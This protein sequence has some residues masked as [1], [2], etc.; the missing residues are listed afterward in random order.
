MR[1]RSMPWRTIISVAA[2]ALL[3]DDINRNISDAEAE[4]QPAAVSG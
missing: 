3:P 2:M 4:D 1:S